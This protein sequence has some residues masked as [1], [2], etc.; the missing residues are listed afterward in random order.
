MKTKI[1]ISTGGSGGHVLPALAFCEHLKENFD[2]FISSDKRGSKFIQS[3]SENLKII[4]VMPLTKNF[5]TLPW[6]ILLFVFGIIKSVI[7]IK[8]N[9]IKIIISTGG[10]MSLP[11][12]IAAKIL[13]CKI[14]LFEPNIVIGR[15]NLFLLNSS[16]FI[17]CYSKKIIN[18]PNKF[19]S[20]LK[21]I[22]PLLRKELY[23][24][25]R[26]DYKTLSRTVKILIIGGSQGADFFQKKLKDLI[27][28][29]SKIFDLEVTHQTSKE[30]KN[31]LESF[32]K[33]NSIKYNLFYFEK[34]IH[35]L[36]LKSN[37]C[38]TRSGASSLAELVHLNLPFIAIPFP[39]AKDNHQYYN[40]LHYLNL[41]CCW[42][43]EQSSNI[44]DELFS[45]I[46]KIFKN[47]DDLNKKRDVMKK[48]SYENSWNNINKKIISFINEN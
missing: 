30:N 25:K 10:Y 22:P 19:K 3:K 16:S 28:K 24:E 38:I 37:L 42:M 43:V 45:L 12:C 47:K 4:N 36:I 9:K 13:S 41:N 1:L 20:K 27:L 8:K 15:A 39:Y 32:Y 17:F 34:S 44:S 23:L 48:I 26:N 5:L 33:E 7:L 18:F 21:L 46:S 14:I 31:N 6:N 11:V 2:V 40:A 29:L 35:K